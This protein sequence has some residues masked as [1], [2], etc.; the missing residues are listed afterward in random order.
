MNNEKI[1]TLIERFLDA[2]TTL[3]EERM[4]YSFFAKNDIPEE[5]EEYRDMFA[6]YA[7]MAKETEEQKPKVVKLR[8]MKPLSIAASLALLVAIG[9][10]VMKNLNGSDM[11]IRYE[12]GHTV[13]DETVVMASMESTMS[14]M[15]ADYDEIDVEQ[16]MSDILK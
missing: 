9:S 13:T 6:G 10:L 7:E 15:F 3:E 8:W 4:L 5:F 1:H 12:N 14:D 11:Y 2:E 16:Q